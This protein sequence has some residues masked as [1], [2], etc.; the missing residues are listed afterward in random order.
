MVT[1]LQI[2]LFQR[3]FQTRSRPSGKDR[4]H[5]WRPSTTWMLY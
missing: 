3:L 1:G 2:A 4:D 5:W